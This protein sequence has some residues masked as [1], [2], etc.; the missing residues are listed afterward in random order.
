MT[1]AESISLLNA[2]RQVRP[3]SPHLTIYQPQITWYLSGLNRVT[4]VTLSFALYGA[5]LIYLLHPLYPSIDSVHL[6]QLVSA[7]PAW[8]KSGM[9]L[10]FAVPFAFHFFNGV[11]HLAWDLRKGL[12]LKGVYAGGYTVLGLTAVSS[13]YLAFFV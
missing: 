13:L 7:M 6:V 12:S 9:K 2:Q 11:R 1:P 5:S 4:G 10:V 3:T 8:L